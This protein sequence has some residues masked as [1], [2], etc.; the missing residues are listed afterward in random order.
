[1]V[2]VDHH[3]LNHIL[4]LI[5]FYEYKMTASPYLSVCL[6][7]GTHR[8]PSTHTSLP[9]PARLVCVTQL[10][11]FIF[12]LLILTFIENERRKWL[13]KNVTVDLLTCRTGPST[14]FSSDPRIHLLVYLLVYILAP[15]V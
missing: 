9:R 13:H 7:T 8:T 1:M 4:Q 6:S 3:Q 11:R 10:L 2:D 12:S 15:D 5:L 14:Q